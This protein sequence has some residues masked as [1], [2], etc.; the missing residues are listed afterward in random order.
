MKKKVKIYPQSLNPQKIVPKHSLTA[1]S[2]APPQLTYRGGPLLSKVEI[3]TVFW[4]DYW[5]TQQAFMQKINN[6]FGHIVSSSL[7]DQL[8]EYNIPNY[9][10]S[11]GTFRGSAIITTPS[12]PFFIFGHTIVNDSRIQSMIQQNISSNIFPTGNNILYAIFL[13]PGVT[14]MLGLSFSCLH[15]CGYHSN[16]Q[17]TYYAVM[18]YPDCRGCTGGLSPFDALTV[19]SSHELCEAITD[20]IPGT[21][22]YDDANGEIGDICPWQTK[23]VDG[24]T[25]QTEW[26]NSA[27]A[28][29]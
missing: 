6:F 12:L 11:S 17:N 21:G 19:T 20:P 3:F 8:G 13:P 7:I 16:F 25:V 26:S 5:T 10:I 24:Y 15:F 18:P 29:V 1:Q 28:C 4:G 2:S 27:N 9:T 22:W 14:A 23:I